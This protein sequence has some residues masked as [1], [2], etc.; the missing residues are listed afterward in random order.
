MAVPY[1]ASVDIVIP[2]GAYWSHLFICG[3]LTDPADP[4]TFVPDDMTGYA[5]QGQVRKAKDKG[6]ALYAEM[7]FNTDNAAIGEFLAYLTDQETGPIPGHGYYDVELHGSQVTRIA[8][9]RAW[10]D[11][12][13]TDA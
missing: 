5:P 8:Q 3:H 6:S 1:M 7:L 9:G 12:E 4:S 13:V 2:Q 11:S 10:L